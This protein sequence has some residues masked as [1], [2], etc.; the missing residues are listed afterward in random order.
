MSSD[1]GPVR[2]VEPK[3]LGG[4]DVEVCLG[5]CG[6]EGAGLGLRCLLPVEGGGEFKDMVGGRGKE[7][8]GELEKVK[9]TV[10]GGRLTPGSTDGSE[11]VFQ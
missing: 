8:P 11:R 3:I 9:T 6:Q 5:R 7:S 2:S 10:P 4:P 1:L